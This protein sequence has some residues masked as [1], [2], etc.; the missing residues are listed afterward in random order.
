MG[1]GRP[2]G[3]VGRAQRPGWAVPVS[4]RRGRVHVV[5]LWTAARPR[6]GGWIPALL[7]ERRP[8]RPALGLRLAPESRGRGWVGWGGRAPPRVVAFIAKHWSRL[9]GKAM[10][11]PSLEVL[12]KTSGY[13]T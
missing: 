4:P 3:G 10:Q 13:G 7:G 11:T 6:E 8:A 9:P 5:F 12:R 2:G 1:G